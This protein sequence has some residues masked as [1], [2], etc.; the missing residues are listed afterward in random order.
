MDSG[1]AYTVF[2]QQNTVVSKL[3]AGKVETGA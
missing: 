3:K 2:S 1:R